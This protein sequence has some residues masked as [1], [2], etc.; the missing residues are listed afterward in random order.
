M[1]QNAVVTKTFP[2]GFAEINPEFAGTTVWALSQQPP[3]V[4]P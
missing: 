3:A 2:D 4:F 1:K